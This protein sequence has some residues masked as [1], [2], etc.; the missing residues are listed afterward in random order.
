MTD[1]GVEMCPGLW[2]GV[3]LEVGLGA[4]KPARTSRQRWVQLSSSEA[5]GSGLRV[6][7]G[8][9]GQSSSLGLP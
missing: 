2:E 1:L 3:G 4:D 5:L 9:Q 6:T 8:E 7:Q